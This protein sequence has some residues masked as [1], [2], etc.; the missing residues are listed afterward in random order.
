LRKVFENIQGL[1]FE[2]ICK[3]IKGME[4]EEG[5]VVFFKN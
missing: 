4:S 2:G 3:K 1:K 5:E